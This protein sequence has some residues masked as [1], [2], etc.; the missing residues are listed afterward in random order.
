MTI[1]NHSTEG[2]TVEEFR[3]AKVDNSIDATVFDP[4]AASGK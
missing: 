4:P 3:S 2:D 1:V